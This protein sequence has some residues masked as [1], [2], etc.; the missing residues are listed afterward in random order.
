MSKVNTKILIAFLIVVGFATRTKAV[1]IMTFED[2][3]AGNFLPP[4]MFTIDFT[5]DQISAEWSDAKTG[6]NLNILGTI[7]NDAYF[8]MHDVAYTGTIYGGQTGGGTIKFFA[9]EQDS[10]T[11]PLI[12][13]DF[14]SGYVSPYGF[15]AMNLGTFYFDGV[16]ISGAALGGAVIEDEACFSY[17]FANQNYSPATNILTATAA[18]TSSAAAPEPATIFLFGLGALGLLRRKSW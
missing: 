2:P 8:I 10:S 1:T 16:S 7:Y 3:T 9:D 14:D 4:P 18:F 12:Q 6:L 15:G 5:A 11:T 17:S 13:F